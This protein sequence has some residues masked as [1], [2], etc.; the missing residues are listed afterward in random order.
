MMELPIRDC[1]PVLPLLMTEN[2]EGVVFRKELFLM[3]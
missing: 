2:Y 3:V 1:G